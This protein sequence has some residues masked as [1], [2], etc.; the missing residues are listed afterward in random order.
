[1][2]P[3]T[4]FLMS[5]VACLTLNSHGFV[6]NIEVKL[7]KKNDTNSKTDLKDLSNQFEV[8]FHTPMSGKIATS[9][10]S[11]YPVNA[12]TTKHNANVT[13]GPNTTFKTKHLTSFVFNS[14]LT[15]M[16]TSQITSTKLWSTQTQNKD[17]SIY[18]SIPELSTKPSSLT[19]IATNKDRKLP[20]IIDNSKNKTKLDKNVTLK[21]APT[22]TYTT[23]KVTTI[24]TTEYDDYQNKE[25]DEYQDQNDLEI[26]TQEISSIKVT[27]QSDDYQ[28]IL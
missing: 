24:K 9:S 15:K 6:L 18:S 19:K 12:L 27:T 26:Q 23:Q 7:V 28:V 14:T 25:F 20:K 2:E 4:F 1:M 5:I 13:Q 11:E 21:T 17:T 16:N 22:S 8:F 10:S 3:K